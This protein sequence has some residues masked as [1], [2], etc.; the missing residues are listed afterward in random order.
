MLLEG[1]ELLEVCSIAGLAAKT[2]EEDSKSNVTQLYLC[3]GKLTNVEN[4]TLHLTF[5]NS[6]E[7]L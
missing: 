2:Y 6:I 7:L 1:L 3:Y 5:L 4:S